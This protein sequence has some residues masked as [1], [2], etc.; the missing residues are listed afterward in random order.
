[1]NVPVSW[2]G[3]IDYAW[4]AAARTA[5]VPARR[6]SVGIS[7]AGHTRCVPVLAGAGVVVWSAA[8]WLAWVGACPCWRVLPPSCAACHCVV[9][10]SQ[11]RRLF[12]LI[13]LLSN[14]SRFIMLR[15]WP[16]LC[17]QAVGPGGEAHTAA[18][19]IRQLH[20]PGCRCLV[21]HSLRCQGAR[22]FAG[23]RFAYPAAANRQEAEAQLAP[24][25]P[26]HPTTT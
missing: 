2:V 5:V 9:T 19:A 21:V 18:G 20:R 4:A 14:L 6:T 16:G 17:R 13:Y 25:E 24:D 3:G 26:H 11:S 12:C 22:S 15:S 7:R 1:L 8:P 10:L 23:P